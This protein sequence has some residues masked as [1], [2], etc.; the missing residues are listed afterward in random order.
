MIFA[1]VG[2]DCSHISNSNTKFEALLVT[3]LCKNDMHYSKY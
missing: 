3:F 2:A 1:V